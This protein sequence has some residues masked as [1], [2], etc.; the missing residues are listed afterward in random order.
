MI[1]MKKTMTTSLTTQEL[2]FIQSRAFGRNAR[3]RAPNVSTVSAG[4]ASSSRVR[5]MNGRA[6]YQGSPWLAR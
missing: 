4:R 2:S 5:P 3:A 6:W 1:T